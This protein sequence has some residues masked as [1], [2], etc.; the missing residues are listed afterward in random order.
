MQTQD[1]KLDADRLFVDM[2]GMAA[3]GA[4][5]A[6]QEARVSALLGEAAKSLGRS[7]AD[8]PGAQR[9]FEAAGGFCFALAK[10]PDLAQRRAWG[11]LFTQDP[12]LWGARAFRCGAFMAPHG[13]SLMVDIFLTHFL[14]GHPS[15]LSG[16]HDEYWSHIS[17]GPTLSQASR[18][19]IFER[20]GASLID[21]LS[22]AGL[23]E[24]W[25][26]AWALAR[27]RQA[28]ITAASPS[29]SYW[30]WSARFAGL[31]KAPFDIEGASL[32][33][34]GLEA[35]RQARHIEAATGKASAGSR[36]NGRL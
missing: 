9:A 36:D 4:R 3:L 5:R 19:G 34:M 26:Q 27:E 21:V 23:D 31:R 30:M 17:Q 25:P 24:R 10:L 8:Y 6:P 20:A 1:L 18:A 29:Y 28:Q 15:C 13:A 35:R 7:P 14:Q 32:A 16:D 22:D 33:V 11:E 2:V 12:A